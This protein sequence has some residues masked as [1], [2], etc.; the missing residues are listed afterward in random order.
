MKIVSTFTVVEESLYSVV[1]DN[2][3]ADVLTKLFQ[4]WN[5]PEY[6]HRFFSK[7]I[8]D[9]RR[10]IWKGI[11]VEAA[12]EFTRNEA[13][14]LEKKLLDLANSGKEGGKNLSSHFSP[15]SDKFIGEL[16]KDKAKG[17][18]K[19]SWLRIYAIRVDENLFVISGG[20]IKLT[21]KMN[22]VPHLDL[23]LAKLELTKNYLQDDEDE[24][25]DFMYTC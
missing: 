14:K 23:E 15:L 2:D 21:E 22:N 4:D 18:S 7:N 16:E 19:N 8:N 20:A 24:N 3:M 13:K 5:D 11:S 10:P 17:L 9:L 6:L 12:I 25:L 1:Y